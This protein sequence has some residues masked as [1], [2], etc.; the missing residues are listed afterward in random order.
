MAKIREVVKGNKT[1]FEVDLGR[2]AGKRRR[3]FK[4]TERLAERALKEQ[5]RKRK[6]LG[7]HWDELDFKSRWTTLEILEE[8]RDHGVTLTEVWETYQKTHLSHCKSTI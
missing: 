4:P 1:T 2:V 8:M 5:E 7:N 3:L 6:M